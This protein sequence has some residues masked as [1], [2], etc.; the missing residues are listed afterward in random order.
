MEKE[1]HGYYSYIQAKY[2]KSHIYL[3]KNGNEVVVT[4]VCDNKKDGNITKYFDDNVYKG[5]V[6]KYVRSIK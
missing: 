5:I 4:E 3:D 2:V 6:T 1:L